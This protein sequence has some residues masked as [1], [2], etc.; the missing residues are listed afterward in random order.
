MQF[1]SAAPYA[2]LG[3][4]LS[5]RLLVLDED[6]AVA[7]I[8]LVYTAEGERRSLRMLPVDGIRTE[9]TYS[10][11]SATV[12][13]EH[14]V[15]D[16]F[17]YTF[18]VA[19]KKGKEYRIPLLEC[20]AL[21]PFVFTEHFTW[22]KHLFAFYEICNPG[23]EAVDL[24]DYEVLFENEFGKVTGRNPMANAAGVNLL[25]GGEVAVFRFVDA[26]RLKALGDAE[27]ETEQFYADVAALF[28]LTCEKIEERSPRI[29]T[30]LTATRDEET[31][32]WKQNKGTFQ[33]RTKARH[34]LHVVRKGEGAENALYTA[35]FNIGGPVRQDIRIYHTTIMHV[36]FRNPCVGIIDNHRRQATPGFAD[37][38]QAF[39]TVKDTVVPAILPVTPKEKIYLASGDVTVRFAVPGQSVSAPTVYVKTGEGYRAYPAMLG[40]EGLYEATVP[41]SAVFGEGGKFS[42]YIEVTGG[43]YMATAGTAREPLTLPVIDNAGPVV[44]ALYPADGQALE[45]VEAPTVRVAFTDPSGVDLKAS[46]I[47]LDGR[48][49]SDAAEWSEG[50]VTFTPA[51]PL[52]LGEHSLELTLRDTLGNRTYLHTK[53]HLTDGEELYCFR[54]DVHAH[55]NE[56]DGK[57]DVEEAI[58]YARDVGKVDYFAVTD[59]SHYLT[60][61]EYGTQMALANKYN[62]NGEYAV[63][64]GGEVTWT[65]VGGFWGH[66]NLLNTTWMDS[67]LT[68]D[69]PELYRHIAADP[70]AVA[71]FN[72]PCVRWG[73]FDS[74]RHRTDEADEKIALVEINDHGFDAHYAL[75]LSR[76]WHAAPVANEDNHSA[77]WTTRTAGTGVVLAHS[78]TREN[79][80]DAFRRRRTYTTTDGTMTIRYRVNNQWLG[81]RLQKPEKLSVEVD[82]TTKHPAGLGTISI[83]TEDNIIVAQV[84]A[85]ALKA[86]SWRLELDPDFDYYY[87]RVRNGKIYAVT[88]PVFVEGWDALTITEMKSGV[89]NDPANPFVVSATVQNTGDKPMTDVTVDFYLTG[90]Y[91]FELRRQ[92]PM[93]SV[94]VGRLEPGESRT[95]SRRF[96]DCEGRHRVSAVT[97]GTVGKMRYADTGY[98]MVSPLFISKICPLTAPHGDV[99]NPFSFV[100]VTNM[101]AGEMNLSGYVLMPW[102]K[103]GRNPSPEHAVPLDGIVLPAGGSMVMWRRPKGSGL[104]VEEFNTRH[105]SALVEGENL[106]VTEA[107]LAKALEKSPILD[108][109]HGKDELTRICFGNHTGGEAHV[110]DQPTFYRPHMDM[111][112]WQRRMQPD[113][114]TKAGVVAPD[115]MPAVMEGGSYMDEVEKAANLPVTSTKLQRMPLNPVRA[116]ALVANAFSTFK[117]FFFPKE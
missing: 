51:K 96:A 77:N 44:T 115:Q 95:V 87:V 5:L 46:S 27:G 99:E 82:I 21:P 58:L 90:E 19:G 98:L 74:F 106:L 102:L 89:S 93:E 49:V 101:T 16:A 7:K 110:A 24:F 111:S 70:D 78:L 53:F 56:S 107:P 88:A 23:E 17:L 83:I 45:N 76:G 36:D 59:H 60:D 66:M 114:P 28:P 81:S 37:E 43:M 32:A 34:R 6:D 79:V 15:G 100:E 25:A 33:Q 55:T 113:T 68:L 108:I 30:S 2:F 86:F 3:K 116:A 18:E 13:A 75:Q 103:M 47:C 42:Y 91:A 12:P 38:M 61:E 73:E 69:L 85:G 65:D 80:L 22:E 35:S 84:E 9:E 41:S 117:G 67:A 105:G 112:I 29:I 48:N 64:Y 62:K 39:P 40:V 92:S 104:T 63:I 52:P 71:M 8:N 1:H 20:P 50:G 97:S 26:E 109:R 72:H 10:V 54:G 4:P 31:G 57:G 14:L 11:Y 94:A